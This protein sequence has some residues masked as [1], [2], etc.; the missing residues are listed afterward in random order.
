MKIA[1]MQLRSEILKFDE[2]L[3]RAKN[4]AQNVQDADIMVFPETFASGFDPS[5]F[6]Q[7]SAQDNEK[8]HKFLSE[9]SAQ[10]CVIAGLTASENGKIYNRAYVYEN[11]A[12]IYTYDKIFLF[13]NS[14]EDKFVKA[15]DK[16]GLCEISHDDKPLK[17]GIAICYDL[18]FGEIFRYLAKN[19]AQIIF[20]IAQFPHSRIEHFRTL[21]RARAIETQCFVCAVNSAA[22]GHS[23][24]ISPQ[25][26][27]LCEFGVGQEWE[28]CDINLAQISLARA[29][30]DILKDE[31]K[32]ILKEL[33]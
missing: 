22:G 32:D 9:I 2:N 17:I 27:I 19:G 25:G 7:I 1:L 14:S 23:C 10:K 12:K 6:S 16:F 5:K 21:L 30:M 26:E 15:G 28:I 24:S 31:R 18:R 11:G 33:L 4:L 8:A 3:L 13:S 29:Q 20:V